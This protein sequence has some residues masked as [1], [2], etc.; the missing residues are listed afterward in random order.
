[1]NYP[2]ILWEIIAKMNFCLFSGTLRFIIFCIDVKIKSETPLRNMTSKWNNFFSRHRM[3]KIKIGG[4]ISTFWRFWKTTLATPKKQQKQQK[5]HFCEKIC[6]FEN[7]GNFW[8]CIQLGRGGVHTPRLW[9]F[10]GGNRIYWPPILICWPDHIGQNIRPEKNFYAD[11]GNEKCDFFDFF[12][13]WVQKEGG[14]R[15]ALNQR[16]KAK[17]FPSH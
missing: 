2:S 7:F 10:G 13:I 15:I 17:F 3:K 8:W 1:M 9:G 11:F 5:Q 16:Q 12:K 14:G 4:I 6:V